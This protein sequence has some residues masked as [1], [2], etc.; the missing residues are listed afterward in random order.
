MK[1]ILVVD[2]SK[3]L[4]SSLCDLIRAEKL[5]T[6]V[7]E[8]KDGVNA[9]KVYKEV[10]PDLVTMDIDMPKA[11]GLQA[12]RAIKKINSDA[13]VIVITG[14]HK[15]TM[16]DVSKFGAFGFLTKPINT[17]D[18]KWAIRNSTKC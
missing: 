11:N 4:R 2:D 10:N 16:Q 8:A 17:S 1:S 13:K 3:F 18:A 14:N 12:L 5:A 15:I 9:V 6:D 7:F